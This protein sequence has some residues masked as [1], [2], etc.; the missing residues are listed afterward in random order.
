M[1]AH[2]VCSGVLPFMPCV[3]DLATVR[4]ICTQPQDV[5]CPDIKSEVNGSDVLPQSQTAF[6][7]ALYLRFSPRETTFRRPKRN[8]V[9]SLKRPLPAIF[10]ISENL[11]MRVVEVGDEADFRELPYP[12]GDESSR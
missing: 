7:L 8:P 2:D 10:V 12:H 11:I 4:S 6:H 3:V 1:P 9:K 5:V